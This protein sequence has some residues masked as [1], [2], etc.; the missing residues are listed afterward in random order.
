MNKYIG[1]QLVSGLDCEAN[2]FNL[3]WPWRPISSNLHG[4]SG[5]MQPEVNKP[6]KETGA[7]YEEVSFY[8]RA[9]HMSTKDSGWHRSCR[10]LGGSVGRLCGND[11][12]VPSV[13]KG[14]ED[15]T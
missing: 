12:G 3:L 7:Y 9:F 1:M 6:V 2:W 15:I 8:T 4:N 5:L 11:I 13:L 10:N 14:H